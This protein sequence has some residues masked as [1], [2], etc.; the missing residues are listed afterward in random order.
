MFHRIVHLSRA[1]ALLLCCAAVPI[2]PAQAQ[3]GGALLP[4]RRINLDGSAVLSP[5]SPVA[6][7]GAVGGMILLVGGGMSWLLWRQATLDDD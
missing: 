5:L 4:V 6:V 7:A 1:S 2:G 3:E